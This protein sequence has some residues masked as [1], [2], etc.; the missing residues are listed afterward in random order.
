MLFVEEVE[1]P[2]RACP[3]RAHRPL[4]WAPPPVSPTG[5]GPA[6]WGPGPIP[7]PRAVG[8]TPP[9]AKG[10]GD[11]GRSG[12]LHL[13]SSDG[14][15]LR[16]HSVCPFPPLHVCVTSGTKSGFKYLERR[17]LSSVVSSLL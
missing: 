17:Y 5:P 3:A 2:T 4:H 16:S 1:Q 12:C 15:K 6:S 13:R 7:H 8:H 11:V 10:R 14:D 9:P